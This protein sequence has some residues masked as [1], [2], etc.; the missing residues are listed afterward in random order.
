[1]N[2]FHSMQQCMRKRREGVN[3]ISCSHNSFRCLVSLCFGLAGCC[4]HYAQAAGNFGEGWPGGRIGRPTLLHQCSPFRITITWNGWPQCI[5]Y[6]P[7]CMGRH[8]QMTKYKLEQVVN[9]KMQVELIY[10]TLNNMRIFK[11]FIIRSLST[12]KICN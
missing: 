1:M 6:N 11:Q 8:K 3:H 5:I 12:Q 9:S 10:R 2:K 4:R 7:T